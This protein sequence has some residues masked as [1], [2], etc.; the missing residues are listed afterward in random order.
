LALTSVFVPGLTAAAQDCQA[1]IAFDSP[2]AGGTVRGTT[3]MSGWALDPSAST[4]SGISAVHIYRDG[5]AG[6]GGV[7]M[8]VANIGGSRPDVDLAYNL[9]NGR[10][11]WQI[12]VDFSGVSA[13]THTLYIY[14]N[15]T[16]GWVATTFD[17]NV[18]A[19]APA[20]LRMNVDMPSPGATAVSGQVLTIGGWA[21]DA[22]AG[23]NVDVVGV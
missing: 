15:T 21:A 2:G 22:D 3:Q 4:G 20:G 12:S 9:T 13:G 1:L 8:G 19:G 6:G 14:A 11:G 23:A 7:G 18:Q 5:P 17:V 16:C 10:T